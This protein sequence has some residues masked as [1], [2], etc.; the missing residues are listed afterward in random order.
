MYPTQQAQLQG[1]KGLAGCWAARDSLATAS[2]ER[3]LKGMFTTR[4]AQILSYTERQFAPCFLQEDKSLALTPQALQP[5][6]THAGTAKEFGHTQ[7]F[8]AQPLCFCCWG[9]NSVAR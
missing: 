2:Q 1:K 4:V 5:L 3:G 8:A 9:Q 6:S 7:G